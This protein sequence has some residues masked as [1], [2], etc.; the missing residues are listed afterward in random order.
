MMFSENDTIATEAELD[1]FFKAVDL[2]E[3]AIENN[4]K[5]ALLAAKKLLNMMDA[6]DNNGRGIHGD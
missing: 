5:E 4:D 3:R 6:A 1:A 2:Y